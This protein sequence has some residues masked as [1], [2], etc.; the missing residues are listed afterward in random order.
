MRITPKYINEIKNF[1]INERSLLLMKK[2]RIDKNNT[3][4][5]ATTGG[6]YFCLINFK[7]PNRPLIKGISNDVRW[8]GDLLLFRQDILWNPEITKTFRPII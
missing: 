7:V 4:F 6:Y 8:I 5:H 1:G 3:E 2:T